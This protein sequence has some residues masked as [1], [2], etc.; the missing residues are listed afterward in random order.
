MNP[1][2]YT[3]KLPGRND[4]LSP[5]SP[6]KELGILLGGLLGGILALYIGLG[7]LVDFLVPR[8][9]METERRIAGFFS[10]LADTAEKTTSR[11]KYLQ[12]LADGLRARCAALPYDIRVVVTENETVNAVAL[13]GGTV[14]VFSGLLEKMSSENELAFVLSH[15]LGHFQ[16]RD[17]L[18][19]MGR[20]LA[21]MALTALVF[22]SD[23]T[24]GEFLARSIGITEMGF[25]RIQE[26]RADEF[27]LSAVNCFY[28]HMGGATVFFEKIR[29]A[30]DPELFGQYFT[31]HPEV[32]ERIRHLT[33]FGS[34]KAFSSGPLK[35]LPGE[36]TS[37][38]KR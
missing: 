32:A 4:N 33:E 23:S 5:E 25:S 34:A 36:V 31:S 15:E 26:T 37:R 20:G 7:L 6:M 24:A 29:E 8:M 21:F 18:R 27:A 1:V 19:A 17:H 13:P 16:H 35:A 11:A 22:G 9:S 30:E 10:Q 2:P 38:D 14:V 28:G 12:A 3:P